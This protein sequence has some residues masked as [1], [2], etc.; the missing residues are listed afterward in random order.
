MKR[1]GWKRAF[2]LLGICLQAWAQ[3]AGT[4]ALAGVITDQSGAA[5]PRAT[6][7]ATN[8]ATNQ[9]R[10]A[11][12]GNDGS[13]RITL[14]PPGMYRITLSATGFRTEEIESF[15]VV[16]TETAALSRS[17]QVGQQAEQITVT[18]EATTLQTE[19]S[20]LGTTVSGTRIANLPLASRNFTA[21]LGMSAGVSATVGDGTAFGRGTVN[22]SVNGAA[23][24]QNN[25]Q[26]DGVAVNNSSGQ[27]NAADGG[28]YTGVGIPNPDALQEFTIV[29]STYDATYGRNPG[30]NVNVVT[31]SGSNQFHGSL[32]E[33]F[34]NEK[35]NAN[36]FF[37]NRDRNPNG[38]ARQVLKQNQFGGT[39]GGRIVR[40]KLFFFGSYQGTRQ[41]NGVAANGST[42]AF[43]FPIPAGDRSQPG[44]RQALGAAMCPANH[45]GDRRYLAQFGA[46][47]T[48][49]VACDGSNISQVALNLLN[50]KL[51]DGSY[52]IPGSGT[53]D[54]INRQYSQ[55]ARYTENQYIANGDWL[56]HPDHQIAM[57]YFFT[58]NPQT[59]TLGGQLP[60][61]TQ[62][63]LFGN[64]YSQLK[65]TSLLT[66][67]LVNQARISFQRIIQEGT[68]QVPYT[69]QQIGLKPMIP[70]QT[71][72][73]VMVIIGAFSIG[74]GLYPS[75]SPT[76][77][78]QIADQI[79]WNKGNHTLRT[80]FEYEWIQWNLVFAGLGRGFLFIG[81]FP[82]LLIGRKGCTTEP[83]CGPGNPGA[84]NGSP[85]SNILSCLF[86]VRGGPNG[87]I[88]GYRMRNANIF[89]QDDWKVT[90]KLTV[91]L[92]VR[93]EYNG[94]LS[95]V[96]GN[97]TNIWT[98]ELRKVPVPPSGPENSVA[99]FTGYVV[100][101]NHLEHYPAPPAGVRVFNGN[102][103]SSNGI[104]K[105]IFGPRI[106]F[107]W[108]ATNR[109]VIRGGFGIFYDRI[110][111]DK[112]VHA[113]QEGKP[114][115]DTISYSGPGAAP[116]SLETPFLERPLA[117]APR[118]FNFQTLQSSNFNSPFYERIGVPL[119]RQYNLSIQYE[120]LPRWVLDV[121]FVGSSG[122][123]Q[124]NYNHNVNTAA[125]AT[126][127][128]PVNGVTTTTVAN[129]NARVPY[130]GFQ[131][132]GL[133][134]TSYD[135]IYNYN[136]G[137]FT[138][139]RQFASGLNIQAAYTWSRGLG[140][141]TNGSANYN[142]AGDLAQQYGPT[143]YN[144]PHRF[145]LNYSWE[146]PA[147]GDGAVRRVFENWTVSGNTIIQSGAAMT[148][149][150]AAG[151]SAFGTGSA[152]TTQGGRSRAQFCPGVTHGDLDTP[153]EVKNRLGG[154][155]GGPGY[156]NRGA[157][158]PPPIIGSD[159]VATDFGNSGMGIMLGPGQH[160]W[161]VGLAKMI[162]I[163]E[164]QT[165][166]FRSE[167][168]NIFN[169]AQFAN[170]NTQR[171]SASFGIIN[172][173]STNPRLIQFALKYA[174]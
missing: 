152:D 105:D 155:S 87:I 145:V 64:T 38:P 95:D 94:T 154:A 109:L 143:E 121:G 5:L 82:D 160:N 16:V 153:G 26:M 162:R 73:P 21:I 116:F 138:L 142:H 27:N 14:L 33:F 161:D 12:T 117:F 42:N 114:Y 169:H 120:F 102:F 65:L 97:L 111:S 174:F 69:P 56:P 11:T 81:G 7:T 2:L 34:R 146:I 112:F 118:F 140:N 8:I 96:Y 67:S 158:C 45:P 98:S 47:N 132:A 48:M 80:G 126:P 159:G 52:Y 135:G 53:G 156:I 55:P 93:W 72:P 10:T 30:A 149:T 74:G 58:E 100:P 63:T 133:Q 17:L 128:R 43:L 99:A 171:N 157:F 167:F 3:S 19:S 88:H 18:A 50:V 113:V 35:L 1:I 36:S 165:V 13:Y 44:F 127:Q 134:E 110:G 151:G 15:P 92:G 172:A 86:C 62:T 49:Q 115:A 46:P 54:I 24:E 124:A 39:F 57:R 75:N 85:S 147:F 37:F 136:S 106:G 25:F 91:N 68:D 4:G 28:L 59:T 168:F 79:S 164:R 20:G 148:I 6:V 61:R 9:S 83:G 108:Q 130:L 104:P 77:Q 90:S 70:T 101:K 84:T 71:Q 137:Q 89:V 66:P 32:F 150:D 107:A 129:A 173:T 123:N 141:I 23:P 60:G 31:R 41:R 51:P 139:R 78:I 166:T 144:R 29:T 22:M 122:I 163:G 131:S 40:D 103:V 170:P 119:T 76:N 125:I